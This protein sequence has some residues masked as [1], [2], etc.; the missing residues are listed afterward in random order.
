MRIAI[1]MQGAQTQSAYRGIGRYVIS[2]MQAMIRK[3]TKHEIVLILNSSLSDKIE[4]IRAAF[5]GLLPQDKIRICYLP[6]K[7]FYNYPQNTK[8]QIVD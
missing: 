4:P 1:D 6:N 8:R 5:D 3:N 2:L 7:V